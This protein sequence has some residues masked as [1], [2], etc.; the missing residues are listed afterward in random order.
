MTWPTSEALVTKSKGLSLLIGDQCVGRKDRTTP[1]PVLW[2]LQARS[3]MLTH[4][5]VIEQQQQQQETLKKVKK[6]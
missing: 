2:P 6:T 4:K 5:Y 1:T 3:S